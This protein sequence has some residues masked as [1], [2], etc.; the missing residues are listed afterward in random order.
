MRRLLRN[1]GS[2]PITRYLIRISVDRY[3]GG[4]GTVQLPLSRASADLGR[5]RPDRELSR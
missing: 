5:A 4:A 3:P 2:E 1:T